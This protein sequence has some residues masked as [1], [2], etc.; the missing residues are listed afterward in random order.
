MFAFIFR[1]CYTSICE[2][3]CHFSVCRKLNFNMFPMSE[4]PDPLYTWK[5]IFTVWVEISFP[6]NLPANG[7]RFYT[8]SQT[9]TTITFCINKIDAHNIITRSLRQVTRY[10]WLMFL[11]NKLIYCLTTH[12]KK[13]W[14][15]I[16]FTSQRYL[17]S[18]P[19]TTKNPDCTGGK[20]SDRVW[21]TI[22]YP[23]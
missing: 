22:E 5:K 7:S 21:V 1:I 13:M 14:H 2:K 17:A 15:F 12:Q 23:V 18:L 19:I 11:L 16:F 6:G 4:L 9:H 20:Q 10:W 8:V 3:N